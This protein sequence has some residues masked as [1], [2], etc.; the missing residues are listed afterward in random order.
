MQLLG[1]AVPTIQKLQREGESGR[2]K[3]QS[4]YTLFNN[5]YLFIPSLPVSMVAYVGTGPDSY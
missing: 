3:D 4:I 1:M 5:R 2:K